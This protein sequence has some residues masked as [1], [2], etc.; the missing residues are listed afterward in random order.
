MCW[1]GA[2]PLPGSGVAHLTVLAPNPLL[3]MVRYP[4][5]SEVLRCSSAGDASQFRGPASP[6]LLWKVAAS[7]STSVQLLSGRV[8]TKICFHRCFSGRYFL[9]VGLRHGSLK[10]QSNAGSGQERGTAAGSSPLILLLSEA[11]AYS[12]FSRRNL[13]CLG[14]FRACSVSS[15]EA[16]PFLPVAV[17][18]ILEA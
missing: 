12:H 2:V 3:G 16:Y 1:G 13:A 17:Q 8:C 6:V 4:P 11:V 7:T 10:S 9:G 18:M 15:V 14:E 5:D